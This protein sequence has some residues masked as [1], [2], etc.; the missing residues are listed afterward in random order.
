[1]AICCVNVD[2]MKQWLRKD[3][4][5]PIFVLGQL[6]FEHVV[7]ERVLK[8]NCKSTNI[9]YMYKSIF[10]IY[11]NNSRWH[12][13]HSFHKN[14]NCKNTNKRKSL[15]T[16]R[17]NTIVERPS[18]LGWQSIVIIA[19]IVTNPILT[20]PSKFVF[21]PTFL[22]FPTCISKKTLTLNNKKISNNFSYDK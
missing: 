21:S 16:P 3:G 10:L 22:S 11:R 2:N 17:V 8:I 1:M 12:I 5:Q 13:V 20:T 19:K 9:C 14:K 18:F 4:I 15:I 7:P 6:F